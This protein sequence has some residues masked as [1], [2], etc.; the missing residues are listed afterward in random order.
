M[1]GAVLSIPRHG[2]FAPLSHSSSCMLVNHG[3]SQ[4]SCKDEYKPWKWGGTS[5][6][7]ASLTKTLLLTRETPS[8]Q[9]QAGNRITW[10]PS[11]HRKETQTA[12]VWT[13]PPVIRSGQN[14]LARQSE[15]RKKPRQ[16]EKEVGRQHQGMDRPGVRQVPEGGNW[17]WSHLWCQ[18][19][20]RGQGIGEMRRTSFHYL[21]SLGHMT[22]IRL[23]STLRYLNGN[24]HR[25][26]RDFLSVSVFWDNKTEQQNWHPCG[27]RVLWN[28]KLMALEH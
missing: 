23:G 28:W 17:L 20:P 5:R 10:R 18:K 26:V 22:S 12:I 27:K 9:D 8:C 11:D 6:Y 19:D 13:C 3:P 21:L 16:T 4:Q 24:C 14:H 2:C 7:Y 25:R 15:K 1:T